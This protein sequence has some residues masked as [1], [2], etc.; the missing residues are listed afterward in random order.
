MDKDGD[1]NVSFPKPPGQ[2]STSTALF[3]TGKKEEPAED[4]FG[5]TMDEDGIHEDRHEAWRF[6]LAG[7]IAGLGGSTCLLF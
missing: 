7:G 1:L 4:E 2:T 3:G 6:L 5:D